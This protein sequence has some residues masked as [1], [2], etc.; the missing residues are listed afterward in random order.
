MYRSKT[1]ISMRRS[2]LLALCL[3]VAACHAGGGVR[4]ALDTRTGVTWAADRA[5]MVFARTEAR[6]SRSARDYVY[7]GPVEVNRQGTRDYYLW[8]GIA[9]TLDR[10]YLAPAVDLPEKLYIDIGDEVLEFALQP[11][12]L[13]VP[14][15]GFEAAYPTAVALRALFAARVTS[16]QIE[17]LARERPRAARVAGAGSQSREYLL[18]DEGS[19][20]QG[21]VA[22]IEPPPARP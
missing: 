7:V 16:S 2:P 6:Y 1:L 8:V 20:W 19:A 15:E 5:P 11:W 3:L 4:E 9:T 21:F 14:I 18:W 17:L 22:R 13:V 10:G 12:R